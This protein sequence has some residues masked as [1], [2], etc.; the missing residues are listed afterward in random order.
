MRFF[1]KN[2]K[3]FTFI[4]LLV[5]IAIIGLLSSIALV[6]LG[7]AR[8][9]ARNAKKMAELR[10]INNAMEICYY[11][12]SC[13][14]ADVQDYPVTYLNIDA[15]LN[16]D[17]LTPVPTG[18]TWTTGAAQYYCVYAALEGLAVNT[19][20]CASNKGVSQKTAPFSSCAVTT[21]P[22]NVDCCG[23]NVTI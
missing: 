11:N 21:A 17:L 12:A 23:P 5:V 22:C 9:K 2:K 19:Y 1:N 6:A 16:P 7:P 13:A 14:V 4:E 8:A 3:G 10:Q 15:D 18:Y 20:F